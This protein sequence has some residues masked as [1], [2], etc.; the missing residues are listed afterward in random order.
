MLVLVLVL[1]LLGEQLHPCVL[2]VYLLAWGLRRLFLL[3]AYL[4]SLVS[5]AGGV[6]TAVSPFLSQ[7]LA[8]AIPPHDE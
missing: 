8:A 2:S 6:S 4:L 5:L 3:C 7:S 1:G